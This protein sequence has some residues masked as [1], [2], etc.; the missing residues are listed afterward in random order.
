MTASG[1]HLSLGL[2]NAAPLQRN[3]E[4]KDAQRR[5]TR[6]RTASITRVHCLTPAAS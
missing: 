3:G 1:V 4:A 6:L 2:A 5:T